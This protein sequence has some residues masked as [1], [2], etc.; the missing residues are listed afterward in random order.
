MCQD[1]LKHAEWKPSVRGWENKAGLW[2]E[3]RSR[4]S[5]VDFRM[6]SATC[7]LQAFW[8]GLNDTPEK[9]E[10]NEAHATPH[11]RNTTTC[12]STKRVLASTQRCQAILTKYLLLPREEARSAAK[13]RMRVLLCQVVAAMAA[14]L[15]TETG[16]WS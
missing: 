5:A 4:D 6:K 11:N 7:F 14:M 10:Y 15:V 8:L 9:V 13:S 1:V 2:V 12:Q 3:N 16:A